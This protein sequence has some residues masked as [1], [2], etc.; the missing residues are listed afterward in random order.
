MEEN[1]PKTGKFARNYGIIL[2]L[3][4]V[5]FAIMLY[6]A[7][8]QYEQSIALFAVN[9]S[10]MIG[11]IMFG[12]Y[13][14]R[15]ANGNILTISEAIKV[16][17]GISLIGAIIGIVYQMIFINLIEP[18]FMANMMEAQK[19]EMITQNPNMSQE[20]IDKAVSMMEK[21]SG[22]FLSAAIGLIG[23]L[24]LGLIISFIG[25][26]ILKKEEAAY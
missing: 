24:F 18:D 16:G 13:K 2:G 17:I 4:T 6:I 3:L 20:E 23:G 22:P 14:F 9:L 7:G 12:I 10:I 1:L 5:V 21:F 25:G 15:E 8:L 26:L 19:M 11:V